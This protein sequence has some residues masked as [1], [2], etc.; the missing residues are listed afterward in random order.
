MGF[1]KITEITKTGRPLGPINIQGEGD[2][3]KTHFMMTGEEPVIIFN[4]DPINNFEDVALQ[5]GEKDISVKHIQY[6][7]PENC[8]PSEAKTIC[9]P[10]W[11]DFMQH[12]VEALSIARTVGID[13]LCEAW[14]LMGYAAFGKVE[15]V[16][17]LAWKGPNTEM[18]QIFRMANSAAINLIVA[19]RVKEEY[20]GDDAIGKKTG[21]LV[22]A[23]WSHLDYEVRLSLELTRRRKNFFAKVLK[24][25]PKPEILSENLK[26]PTFQLLRELVG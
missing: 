6:H 21:R 22:R 15:Q 9:K 11:E 25:K 19:N 14:T 26:N 1:T 18:K 8:S 16:P 23:G 24:F 4:F 3:G 10:A 2:T 17:P 12:Y 5:F 20:I 13:T 7:L